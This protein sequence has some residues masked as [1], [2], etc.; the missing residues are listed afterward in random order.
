MFRKI[1]LAYDGSAGV[2]RALDVALELTSTFGTEL[3]ALAVEERL[4]HYAATVGEME[5]EKEFANHFFQEAL[6]IADLRALKARVELKSEIRAGH[7]ARIIVAFTKEGG[8]D[9]VVL[10]SSG[11]SKVGAMFLGTTTEKV[12]RHIP[13]TVLI[14]R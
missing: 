11:H 6:S 12:S 4:P 9:L 14:V 2:K 5:E 10:G 7:A 1:L 13:C 8:F 3:W